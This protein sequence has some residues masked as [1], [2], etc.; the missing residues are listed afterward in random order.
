M[1]TALIQK[2]LKHILLSPKF[3]TTFAVCS[4]LLLLSVYIGIREYKNAVVEYDNANHLVSEELH[5]GV[6][7]RFRDG[8]ALAGGPKDVDVTKSGIEHM[9]HLLT[10]HIFDE[11]LLFVPRDFTTDED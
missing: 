9:P 2:E 3:T 7:Q 5:H 8:I 11:V 4:L 10:K 6:E 1:I